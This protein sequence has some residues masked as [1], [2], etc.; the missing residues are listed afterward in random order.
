MD[1]AFQRLRNEHLV[2]EPCAGPEDV[3]QW[4]GAVQA[5]DYAGAKWALA[6][7]S[8]NT[9]SAE[10]DELFGSG[11]LL[12]THVMRPTWHFVSPLDI[13]WLLALTA[14]RVHAVNASY[15]RKLELDD[16]IFEKSQ[17]VFVRELQGDGQLTRTELA[18]RLE[19]AGIVANGPRLGYIMMAAELDGVICSGA[20]EGKQHTYALLDERVPPTQPL[21]RER[22]LAELARRYFTS[23]GPALLK[24]FSWWSGLTI[25]DTKS[26]IELAGKRL[27]RAELG[28]KVYW[29]GRSGSTTTR[30]RSPTLH[31]LPNYDE[32]LV[33]YRDHSPSFDSALFDVSAPPGIF[34]GHIVVLDGKVVGG[35]RRTIERDGITIRATLLVSCNEAETRALKAAAK[36]Y[37]TF[38][39][40]PTTLTVDL[41]ERVKSQG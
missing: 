41:A 3:V 27:D 40:K 34:D 7:R 20:L 9:T 33:A 8:R 10:I 31:L 12:R 36:R 6:Q 26:A 18:R 28:E 23:H 30:S 2:G 13:R 38:L 25:A 5:Q 21:S 35:W 1:V 14:P 24:D 15:Y 17:A 22:A 29:S 16:A 11:K 37:G 39:G 32:Y 4:L 19:Q